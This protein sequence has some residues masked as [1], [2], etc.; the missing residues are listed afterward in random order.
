MYTQSTDAETRWQSDKMYL[1]SR[2]HTHAHSPIQFIYFTR[3]HCTSPA[4]EHSCIH[5]NG[6]KP[7]IYRHVLDSLSLSASKSVICNSSLSLHVLSNRCCHS[8]WEGRKKIEAHTKLTAHQHRLR[9]L[10]ILNW[11]PFYIHASLLCSHSQIAVV[12]IRSGKEKNPILFLSHFHIISYACD[13]VFVCTE[14]CAFY[15]ST[16]RN[17]MKYAL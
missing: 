10:L 16:K 6:A 4:N 9:E 1:R 8:E 14:N 11:P 17:A 12:S 7:F 5:R 2:T 15:F 3:S 13:L